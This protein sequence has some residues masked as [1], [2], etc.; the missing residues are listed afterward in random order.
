MIKKI[1]VIVNPASGKPQPILHTLNKVFRGADTDWD[2]ALTKHSGDAERF[3][4]QASENGYD[5]VAGFGGDGT[6]ME[7]A[8]GLLG[9]NTPMGILPG[10][11]ANLMSVELGIPKDLALAAGIIVN[12]ESEVRFVDLGTVNDTYFALRIGMGF[13]AERVKSADRA[14]KDKYGKM[15]YSIGAL[16]ALTKLKKAEY[17]ITL[18][19]QTIVTQG[20]SCFIDNAGNLGKAGFSAA[21]NISISDGL[22]D[23]ILIR[24][25]SYETYVSMSRVLTSFDPESSTFHHWQAREILIETNPPLTLNIDGEIV[26]QT[27]ISVKVIPQAVR[28]M[29]SGS[30][31]A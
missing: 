5:V 17:R 23:V 28:V 26:G 18:D 2:I 6:V 9:T 31:T 19:G 20:I 7:V 15:A 25:A 13:S 29:V 8:R 21:E 24:D 27:P 30:Q 14:L 12:P 16:K 4:R 1:F 3:A 22:L 10:G 11:T